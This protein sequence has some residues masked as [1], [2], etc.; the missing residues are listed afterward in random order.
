ML[1]LIN[2]ETRQ[3]PRLDGGPRARSGQSPFHPAT[4]TGMGD[5]AGNFTVSC[6]PEPPPLALPLRSTRRPKPRD[7]FAILVRQSRIMIDVQRINRIRSSCCDAFLGCLFLSD[8]DVFV[9]RSI[10]PLWRT[11]FTS[12]GHSVSDRSNH[13]VCWPSFARI[14]R[15]IKGE[16]H[17]EN[18]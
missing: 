15:V 18:L 13:G 3:I 10:R 4:P 5:S 14:S 9:P 16:D 8:T 11:M 17:R 1:N 6:I 7:T 12:P 2:K